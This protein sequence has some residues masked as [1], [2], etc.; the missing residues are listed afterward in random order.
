M[1]IK[2]LV[3]RIYWAP[4]YSNAFS[5]G[6]SGSQ[7]TIQPDGTVH[8]HN[9]LMAPGD[10]IMYWHS[11]NNYQ[12]DKSVPQLPILQPGKQYRIVIHGNAFPIETAMYRINFNDRQ[13]HQIKKVMF[14][15]GIQTFRYPLE[16]VDYDLLIINAGG[17]DY[18]F[19]NAEISL[20]SV[21]TAA[22]SEFW[23]QS[24]FGDSR[25]PRI[26]LLIP[27]NKRYKST[28]PELSHYC[29]RYCL[30][31]VVVDPRIDADKLA[32]NLNKMVADDSLKGANL[33]SCDARLA[34]GVAKFASQNID[35]PVLMVGQQGDVPVLGN[36]SQ[37]QLRKPLLP[38]ETDTLDPDWP[39]I[40]TAIHHNWEDDHG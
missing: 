31:P 40:F 23:I 32:T 16:A 33:V 36:V 17:T 12:M 37:F 13:G 26:I 8:Q 3:N 21:S 15:D 10:T 28:F 30:L 5:L 20:D 7:V 39:L 29:H 34:Q 22:N 11:H 14:R 19:D 6:A 2:E 18:Y 38:V 4:E 1:V 9:A 27:A 35:T 25:L 24:P